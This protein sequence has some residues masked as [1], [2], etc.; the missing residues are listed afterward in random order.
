M[1]PGS[2]LGMKKGSLWGVLVVW[3]AW[4][5]QWGVV[6]GLAQEPAVVV[7]DVDGAIEA[8]EAGSAAADVAAAIRDSDTAFRPRD[9][10]ALADEE[11]PEEVLKAMAARTSIFFDPQQIKSLGAYAAGYRSGQPR[12][13][14]NVA[15]G[16]LTE[17]MT[18]FKGLEDQRQA[19]VDGVA[20]PPGQGADELDHAYDLRMRGHQ[21]ELARLTGPI[22][23]QIEAT[24]LVLRLPVA[25]GPHDGS[26]GV[27]SVEEVAAVDFFTFRGGM[28]VTDRKNVIALE[29]RSVAEALFQTSPSR[30]LVATS[31]NVCVPASQWASTAKSASLRGELRRSA[32]GKWS[33]DLEFMDGYGDR[34]RTRK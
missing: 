20:A 12:K 22:D 18:W 27:L 6:V 16:G 5:L 3:F 26:C 28:G 11:V 14:F 9:L 4:W 33:G 30:A 10:Y 23:G 21:Q 32:N 29:S 7:H 31:H 13:E 8:L 15:A 1:T 24:T 34:I 25:A 2:G 17:V 19:L